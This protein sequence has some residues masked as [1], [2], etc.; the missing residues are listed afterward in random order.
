V[1]EPLEAITNVHLGSESNVKG[2][3]LMTALLLD[4]P[5]HDI[6]DYVR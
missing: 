6:R 1:V 3:A 5:L 2:A 4:T